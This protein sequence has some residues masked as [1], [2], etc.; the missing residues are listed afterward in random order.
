MAALTEALAPA[1]RRQAATAGRC[2][3][4]TGA[5]RVWTVAGASVCRWAMGAVRA[6]SGRDSVGPWH[7]QA[8]RHAG[9]G[10]LDALVVSRARLVAAGGASVAARV[11]CMRGGISARMSLRTRSFVSLYRVNI[12]AI[13]GSSGRARGNIESKVRITP[14]FGWPSAGPRLAVQ[15]WLLRGCGI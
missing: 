6:G 4:V 15:G 8:R 1:A 3:G 7:G 14:T 11:R 5:T 2:V 12:V 13:D 9:R 10:P